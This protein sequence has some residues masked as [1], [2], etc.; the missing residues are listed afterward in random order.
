MTTMNT[1]L[2][3]LHRRSAPLTRAARQNY[4]TDARTGK[5]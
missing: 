1:G 5:L 4:L 2:V 3:R